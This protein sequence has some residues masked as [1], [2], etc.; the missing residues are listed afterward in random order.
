MTTSWYTIEPQAPLVFR[1]A[2]PF[3]AG[4][5][6]GANFPWPSSLAGLLRTQI[7]DDNGWQ[8]GLS[9][10][11]QEELRA[12]PVAG[13]LLA[14][15]EGDALTPWLPR[16]ADALLL[17]NDDGGLAYR[18]LQPARLP[19]GCG[20]DLP[21]GLLPL[22]LDG[23]HKGKP[24]AGPAYWPLE[25]M[26]AWGRGETVTVPGDDVTPWVTER[27]TH[28]AIDRETL[29]AQDGKLFQ[30]EGLE[31][32]HRRIELE[33]RPAGYSSHDWVLLAQGP[34]KITPRLVTFGGEGRL[35]WLAPMATPALPAP[36]NL[37]TT[38]AKGFAVTLITP[39]LFADGWRP[40]W[41][42]DRLEGEMPGTEGLRVRLRAAAVERWQSISG[43]DLALWKARPARKAVASGAT[44]WF[45][46]LPGSPP[47]TDALWLAALS[48]N[49]Q[50]RRDGFGIALPRPWNASLFGD[51]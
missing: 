21:A 6:D 8:P 45:E 43:W 7:M 29:A 12:M 14:R 34:H 36:A 51:C 50:D 41:L 31:F 5:R 40:A 23:K 47:P 4:S 22:L 15:R 38:L 49:P 37:A 11:Q 2:K 17:L 46:I 35:S 48:D 26:L 1:T 39:A 25:K 44:Y 20:T 19:P 30:T 24:Q 3:G 16:P 13:P 10:A 18:R 32:G 42:D 28:L 33:G 9:D 27:R